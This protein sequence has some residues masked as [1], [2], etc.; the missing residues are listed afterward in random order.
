MKEAI[1]LVVAMSALPA[2]AAKITFFEPE[3]VAITC[4]LVDCVNHISDD[5]EH[6]KLHVGRNGDGLELIILRK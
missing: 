1:N 5:A 3:L 4:E 6:I 2:N